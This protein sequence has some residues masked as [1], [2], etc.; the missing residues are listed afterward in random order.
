MKNHTMIPEHVA[1]SILARATQLDAQCPAIAIDELRA[2]AAELNVSET[3]LDTAL[4]EYHEARPGPASRR[5]SLAVAALGL[6][7]GL[8]GGSLLATAT[9]FTF[10]SVLLLTTAAGLLS[11]TGLIVLQSRRPSL[12]SYVLYNSLLWGG[13]AAGLLSGMTIFGDVT[14]SATLWALAYGL[15][16]WLPST[17]L[18]AA[19]VTA[20]LRNDAAN[21]DLPDSSLPASVSSASGRAWTLVTRLL[22]WINGSLRI[23]FS[24]APATIFRPVRTAAVHDGAA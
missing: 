2:I 22:A 11:S 20:V 18:G 16:H 24:V 4:S 10:P 14:G 9:F 3:S 7:I 8:V 15:K 23:R 5:S 19:G 17:I 12:N 21:R 6:P 13:I 1:Q